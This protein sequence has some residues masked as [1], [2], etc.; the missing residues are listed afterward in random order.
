MMEF[1]RGELMRWFHE[2]S[3]KGRAEHA[4]VVKSVAL[5][6]EVSIKNR[7][8]RYRYQRSTDAIWEVRSRANIPDELRGSYIVNIDQHTCDCHR[9]Q[10][11]GVPCAHALAILLPLRKDPY[12]FVEPYF[13]SAAYRSTYSLPIFPI[14]DRIEWMPLPIRESSDHSDSDTSGSDS[15]TL[16]PPNTRRPAGH[17]KN[18]RY[19][20]SAERDL[21][22]PK[23]VYRCTRCGDTGHNK[24]S[25]TEPI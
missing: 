13:Y 17:P 25:C 18:K 7:A 24:R 8:R 20:N 2:R 22:K 19:R 11:S 14:P 21:E 9:R 4:L 10:T 12:L 3:A 5:D 23:K 15:D 1:I 16:H 6:I